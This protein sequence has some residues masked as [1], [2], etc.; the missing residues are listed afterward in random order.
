MVA[1]DR[2][3]A[4][5]IPCSEQLRAKDLIFRANHS[6]ATT[7]VGHASNQAEIA[8]EYVVEAPLP[9]GTS[10]PWRSKF[11]TKMTTSRC[12]RSRCGHSAMRRR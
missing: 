2:L 5:V 12:A 7:V 4:V 1:L 6:E 11:R 9:T 3:G 10:G 8:T